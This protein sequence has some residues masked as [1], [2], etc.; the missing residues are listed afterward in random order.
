MQSSATPGT[1]SVSAARRAFRKACRMCAPEVR[2][3]GGRSI[4]RTRSLPAILGDTPNMFSF[5]NPPDS[6]VLNVLFGVCNNN[7]AGVLGRC[8]SS[9]IFGCLRRKRADFRRP[10]HFALWLLRHAPRD[11]IRAGDL[12]STSKSE[13]RLFLAI[14]CVKIRRRRKISLWPKFVSSGHNLPF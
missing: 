6:P 3:N 13:R 1:I 9:T 14:F 11:S 10:C 12:P 7:G 2:T 4:A 8:T 5:R